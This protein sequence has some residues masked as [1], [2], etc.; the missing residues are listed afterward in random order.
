MQRFAKILC[1]PMSAT[2]DVP[3]EMERAVEVAEANDAALTLFGVAPEPP[4]LQRL[5]KVGGKHGSLAEAVQAGLTEVLTTWAQRFTDRRPIAVE[6]VTGGHKPVEVVRE[7]I[8]SGHDLV[9]I[10]TDNSPDASATIRRILRKC[11]CPVWVFQPRHTGGVLAAIDPDHDP[12]LI[13]SILDHAKAQATERGI[14]LHIVYAWQFYGSTPLLGSDYTAMGVA[15]IEMLHRDVEQAHRDAFH[16]VLAASEIEPGEHAHLVE[17]PPSDAIEDLIA[18]YD[19]DL[20]V[21]GTVGRGGIEGFLMGNTA[22]RVLNA[23]EC[24]VLVLKPSDFVSPV[25]I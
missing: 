19:I 13:L 9:A 1:V 23:V 25:K 21:M 24:S 5:L 12:A 22:E 4:K 6:V 10:A 17:L 16:T 7:V 18:G 14:D 20:L 8:R 2:V 3:A 15:A 11:P